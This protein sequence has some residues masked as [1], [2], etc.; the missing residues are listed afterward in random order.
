MAV[1]ENAPVAGY[2]GTPLAK[3]LG[4]T[5]ATRV[6]LVAAPDGFV[7]LLAPLPDGVRII[8]S[9]RGRSDVLIFFAT[10]RNELHRRCAKLANAIAT[11]GGMWIAWP[12]RT[13]NV[14]T[15]LN[16]NLVREI[17]LACGLVDNKV[18]AIDETWSGL[19]FVY[20]VADRPA[21]QTIGKTASVAGGANRATG[22]SH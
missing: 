9:A 8:D 7:D 22:P 14:A 19:R 5:V 13:A 3:K 16:G 20:R 2:S 10:R 12:K 11:D 18:C 21:R 15:D 17:G 4:I 1:S 6:S